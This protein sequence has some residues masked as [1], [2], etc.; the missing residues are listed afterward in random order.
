MKKPVA[1]LISGRGSNMRALIEAAQAPDYP[2]RIACVIANRADAAGLDEA[3]ALGVPTHAIA[4]KGLNREA[5]ET[6]LSAALQASG[7]EIICLAGFMR[8]FTPDFTR[9]WY[10]R[11]LNIHPS[12]LPAFKGLDVHRRV[13]ES[14]VRFTGCTVHFVSPEMDEGPIILQ[15]AIPVP[16]HASPEQVADAVLAEEHKLYPQALRLLA[17]GRLVIDGPRVTIS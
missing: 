5:F 1:I 9:A 3:R 8:L 10:G 7:A 14:G 11:M 2:A 15:A 13:V 16:Q 17:E 12:L 6:Q 4:S